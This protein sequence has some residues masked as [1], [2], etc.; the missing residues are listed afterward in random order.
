[1]KKSFWIIPIALFFFTMSGLSEASE[2]E[3]GKKIAQAYGINGFHNIQ[4]LQFTF[5]AKI[6][7]KV[8]SRGWLWLPKEDKVTYLGNSETN[9]PLSY[10]RENIAAESESIKEVDSWFIND[11]YW[12][13]FPFHLVWDEGIKIEVEEEKVNLPIGS[14]ITTKVSV[15][16]PD[17]GGYTPGDIYELYL[18][19]NHMILEWIYRRGGAETPTRITTWEDNTQIGPLIISENHLG[20]DKNFR[21]WFTDVEVKLSGFGD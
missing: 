19:D 15:I 13:L 14:G 2:S 1:M 11:Q 10:S 5:N 9:Q 3:I 20:P 12:L 16:Y 4:E 18:D 7:E 8:I 17:D 6:G 21:V